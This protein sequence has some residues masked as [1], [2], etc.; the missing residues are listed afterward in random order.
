MKAREQYENGVFTIRFIGEE[1]T[2][3]GVSIYDLS[4]SLLAIQRIVHKAHLSLEGRLNKGAY[5]KKDERKELALQLGERRRSS[6]AFALV[7]MLID[8]GS[9]DYLIE[10]A[11]FIIDGISGYYIGDLLDRIHKEKNEDK[12]IFIGSI[13][14]EVANIVNRVDGAGGLDAISLGSPLL[15]KETI[16]SFNEDTKEY[17]NQIKDE[18]F[19]G[20]YKEIKGRVYKL[21]PNSRIVAIKNQ[22]RASI[23]IFL[24]EKDFDDIR[25]RKE[26]SPEYIFKGRPK[27]QFG[28]ET[29]R[30]SEFV[31]DEIEYIDEL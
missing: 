16:A 21:Y 20:D 7:P 14:T 11:K 26:T 30:I 25:Y 18:Y 1:L 6:D 28:V 12:K 3:S 29:K 8:K 23:S 9:Q 31:A 17:L 19:L 4:H 10:L 22:G 27:Y 24:S 5:P 2:Q 13:Y 15:K